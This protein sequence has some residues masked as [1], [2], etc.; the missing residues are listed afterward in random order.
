MYNNTRGTLRR[1]DIIIKEGVNMYCRNC[2][3][4]MVDNA[5]VCL[6]CGVAR[7][8]G[9]NFC[10]NCGV[11]TN[12]NQAVCVK[13]GV[14]LNQ[15]QGQNTFS[16]RTTYRTLCRSR[17]GKVLAGVFAGFGKHL[18]INPWA[19]RILYLFLF[20]WNIGLIAYIIVALCLKYE[21]EL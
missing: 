18:D 13:C 6:N 2:G 10:S 8:V 12:Q 4:E 19:L 11:Q 16:A 20:A 15:N 17:D 21:D 1:T 14:N 5:S 7:G 9:L 3:N